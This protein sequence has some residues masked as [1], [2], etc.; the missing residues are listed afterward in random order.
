MLSNPQNVSQGRITVQGVRKRI[1]ASVICVALIV[2]RA[3]SAAPAKP[4]SEAGWRELARKDAEAMAQL[5]RDHSP[6]PFDTEN[7]HLRRWLDEGLRQ[8][9]ARAE[10]VKSESDW[11]YLLAAYGNGFNDPHIRVQALGEL[12]AP[13]WPGFIAT[14]NGDGARIVERLDEP[15]IPPLGARILGCDGKSLAQLA[16]E[17]VFPFTFYAALPADRRRAVTRLFLDRPNAHVPTT[18]ECEFTWTTAAGAQ[19]AVR[20]LAWRTIP[21][22]TE[23]RSAW[24]TRYQ[25]AATGPATTW[26]VSEPA[27]GVFWIGV[28]TFSSGKESAPKLEELMKA[29]EARAEEMRNARAI[30]LDTRGNGGGNSAWADRLARAVFTESVLKRHST[31]S[32]QNAVDWRA[33]HGNAAYWRKWA[34]QMKQEFGEENYRMALRYADQFAANADANPPFVRDGSRSTGASGGLTQKRPKGSSPFPA[35]VY[36]LGNGSCGSSCLN[37]ADRV[38]FV[39]GVKLIGSATSGDGML[40]DVR[41]ETLPSGLASLV[42]PQKVARGRGRGHLE[43]YEP[44]IAYDGAWDDAS[45]RKWVLELVERE[46][47][48]VKEQAA[49]KNPAVTH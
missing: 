22:G 35:K 14:A 21:E 49:V 45:V 36:F 2:A 10:A 4:D 42:I 41:S 29:V 48:R 16:D 24:N 3:A 39:P 40:M 26:G 32:Y 11:F 33:S 12:P 1:F 18:T 46:V 23:A 34:E 5:L 27:P 8:A 30:I 44:D 15:D 6:I 37:F 31:P 19:R 7:P 25:N 28:P 17:R 9:L 43:V 13:R 38:L 20:K 47:P